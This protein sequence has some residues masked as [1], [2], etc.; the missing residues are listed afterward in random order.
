MCV[1][2]CVCVCVCMFVKAQNVSKQDCEHTLSQT[3]DWI[4]LYISHNCNLLRDRKQNEIGIIILHKNF[5]KY[6]MYT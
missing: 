6:A 3:N 1:C 4:P 5:M 2:V